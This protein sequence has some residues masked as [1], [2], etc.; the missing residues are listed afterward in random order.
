LFLLGSNPRGLKA[1]GAFRVEHGG[2]ER[3][4]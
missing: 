4:P 2:A 3:R 1:R